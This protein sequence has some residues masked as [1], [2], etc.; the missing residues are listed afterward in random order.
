SDF[1]ADPKKQY[2]PK[3]WIALSGKE[4]EHKVYE[5]TRNVLEICI[6]NNVAPDLIQIGNE[7]TNGMLWPDG[8]TPTYLFEER[9]FDEIDSL[10]RKESYD[11]LAR[12]LKEGIKATK[13]TL[14]VTS[15]IILHL[16]FGGANDLYRTWFDEVSDR[17]VDF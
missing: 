10:K 13:D 8:R 1:W 11:Q 7:I 14:Q 17:G 9:K 12:L 4:L 6:E 5:Y 3:S 15:K 2:K 16:D